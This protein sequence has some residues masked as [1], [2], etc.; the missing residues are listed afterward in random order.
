VNWGLNTQF[1]SLSKYWVGIGE[2][3]PKINEIKNLDE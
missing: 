2:E 1:N 3:D